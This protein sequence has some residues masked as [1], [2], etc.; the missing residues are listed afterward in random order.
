MVPLS[1]AE[2]HGTLWRVSEGVFSKRDHEFES[3]FLQQR[4]SSELV[5]PMWSTPNW[6][7][8]SEEVLAVTGVEQIFSLAW[9]PARSAHACI[10]GHH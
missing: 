8:R 7:C 1:S 9:N 2:G 10:A 6:T 3:A 4:V 5:T